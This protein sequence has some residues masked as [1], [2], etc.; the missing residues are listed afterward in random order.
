MAIPDL[1]VQEPPKHVDYLRNGSYSGAP[2]LV[3][4][5]KTVL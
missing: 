3:N 2:Q 1:V 5:S 4:V